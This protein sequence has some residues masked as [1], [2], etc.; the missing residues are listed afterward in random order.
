M[1]FKSIITIEGM[2]RVVMKD[3]N[4]LAY[5]L[6][7]AAELVKSKTEPTKMLKDLSSV[8]RDF[9][10]LVSNLPRQMRQL[11]RRFT[12]PDFALKVDFQQAENYRAATRSAAQVIGMGILI[13]SLVLSATMLYVW[14]DQPYYYGIPMMTAAHYSAAAFLFIFSF[15]RK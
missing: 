5:S 13:S 15:V 6:E 14:A 2:G 7:F 1:Y 12:S 4:F 11:M 8:G 3:F 10:A 9:N